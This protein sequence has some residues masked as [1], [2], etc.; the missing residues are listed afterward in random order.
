[1]TLPDF[2]VLNTPVQYLKGVG[3]YLGSLFEKMGIKTLED[4]FY[5][6]PHRYLDRQKVFLI[7]E[8][9]PGP[10]RVVKGQLISCGEASLGRGRRKMFQALFSD[11]SG[12]LQTTWFN[13]YGK[14]LSKQF[15]KGKWAWISGAADLFRGQLQMVHPEIEWA[16]DE[17]QV[18][19]LVPNGGGI[20]PV[21]PL[22]EGFHQKKLRKIMQ[23]AQAKFL[24]SLSETLPPSLLNKND[25][26]GYKK[27]LKE[28]H[29][30]SPGSD[31]ESLNLQSSSAH[32]RLIFDEFFFLELG[33]ALKRKGALKEKGISISNSPQE[34]SR[35]YASLP[36]EPTGAQKRAI[37]EINLDLSRD[38]PM[39]RL[40]QGDVGSG[41][42]LVG[43]AAALSAISGG[44]QACLMAPTEILAEQHAKNLK[45]F[46][47]PLDK[48]VLLLKSDL[49]GSE[50]KER[51]E[52]IARG[53]VDLVVGT[54]ALIQEGV[55]FKSLALA[56]IDEQHRFGVLQRAELKRKGNNPHVLV[57][58]AT[59]IPRTL[60]MTAY[61]D[62]D[63]SILDELPK[64]RQPILTKTVY[65]RD[66]ARLY[67]FIRKETGQ[68]RQAYI[69]Y[70]L[71]EESE[72]L[73]LKNATKMYDHLKTDVFPDLKVGLVHGQMKGEQKEEV[74]SQFLN[75]EIQIL[76]ATTVIEVGVDVPN[77][78]LMVI[79]HAERFGL[80]QLHQM[81]GRVGRG[82]EK[83]YCFLM[84]AWPQSDTAKQ[85]LK[86]MGETT[87]GF[88]IA[89]E[90]LN[91]RGPGDFLGTR[92]AGLPD[93]RIAHLIRDV[94]ILE[95]ARREAFSWLEQDPGLNSPDSQ[96]MKAILM[97]R[98]KGRLNLA[99]IG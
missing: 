27:A 94:S 5:H 66:R 87:D 58:T 48:R 84:A 3:P 21:Y 89:E 56:I 86:I 47:A 23:G 83:S 13:Y 2:E 10:D 1:M 31:I 16:D 73:E 72:A 54:H 6:I 41:K 36:F 22:T 98:W 52:K 50:R 29:E 30:P 81:R 53:E 82:S 55:E 90:D 42:T 69:V 39:H 43:A 26:I 20:I 95:K 19:E 8:L 63:L 11:G 49:T 70:P 76:V 68:G 78:T 62:L 67:E 12:Y 32:R 74:I 92:Q 45:S 79:E 91:L 60:A 85:R 65:E 80:S 61:G 15:Q 97:H 24:E 34:L 57:M 35:F 25:L 99:Q 75:K 28:I 93:F 40:L 14:S 17:E 37:E 46:L 71:V 51:L 88:K 96:K 77:A 18:Q 59:P 38:K 64:G 7:S 33:L 4:L 9:S 44:F